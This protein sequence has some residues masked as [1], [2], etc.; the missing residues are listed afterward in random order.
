MDVLIEVLN[1]TEYWNVLFCAS[2]ELCLSSVKKIYIQE[3]NYWSD[4]YSHSAKGL[5]TWWSEGRF[6]V[7]QNSVLTSGVLKEHLSGLLVVTSS[8]L[9]VFLVLVSLKLK[10][11]HILCMSRWPVLNPRPRYWSLWV[12]CRQTGFP[13]VWFACNSSSTGLKRMVTARVTGDL[14][15]ISLTEGNRNAS[16]PLGSSSNVL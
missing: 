1:C 14:R 12:I 10:L 5:T 3:T 8:L 6:T 11:P 16:E 15:S 13:Y 4:N 7:L 2:T 9:V